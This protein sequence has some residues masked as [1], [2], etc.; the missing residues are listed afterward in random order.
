MKILAAV[1]TIIMGVGLSATA[2]A[3]GAPILVQGPTG[4]TLPAQADAS[5]NQYVNCVVG[6][7]TALPAALTPHNLD[8]DFITTGGTAVVALTLGHARYGGYIHNPLTA[9]T[10]L[11][12]SVTGTALSTEAADT[13]GATTCIAPGQTFTIAPEGASSPV[14]SVN[15]TDSAHQYSGVGYY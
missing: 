7:G 2:F 8:G 12:V 11:C 15:T 9:T 14:V 3:Q 6:C 5:G 10:N 1:M 13:N 4:G